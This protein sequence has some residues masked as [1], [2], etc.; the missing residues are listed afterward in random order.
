MTTPGG[1]LLAVVLQFWLMIFIQFPITRLAHDV[2]D[3]W[4]VELL[5][6]GLY[7]LMRC[8]LK[9]GRRRGSFLS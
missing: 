2:G 9:K 5:E 7:L 4:Q 1:S 8:S 6:L 3:V